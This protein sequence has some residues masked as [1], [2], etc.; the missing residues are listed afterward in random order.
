MWNGYSW[1]WC[2]GK[3]G[4]S[5][6]IINEPRSHNFTVDC[7][8]SAKTPLKDCN[9][10]SCP[11]VRRQK[12]EW[13]W[14]TFDIISG[15]S[16]PWDHNRLLDNKCGERPNFLGRRRHRDSQ[17]RRTARQRRKKQKLLKA[18]NKMCRSKK[19]KLRP[20]FCDTGKLFIMLMCIFQI[21][22][23]EG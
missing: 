14:D 16:T 1:N 7:L 22:Q 20:K 2:V 9:P 11:S 4:G 15:I 6:S 5:C 8:N 10:K 21:L 12:T 18:K 3:G 17:R 23:Q 13:Q 19:L